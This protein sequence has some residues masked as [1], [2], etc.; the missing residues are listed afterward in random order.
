MGVATLRVI[1][2]ETGEITEHSGCPHCQQAQAETEELTKK[3]KGALLEIRKLK[4]DRLAEI[5]GAPERP[6]VELLHAVWKVACK[7]R[8]DL[9][10]K[11]YERM[12]AMVKKHGLGKCLAAIAGASYDCAKTPRKN[13]T[14]KKHDDLE[15]IFRESAKVLDFA[16]RVPQGWTPNVEKVAHIGGVSEQ[17]VADILEGRWKA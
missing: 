11:D 15:L 8:R 9:D 13:G 12:N 3:F 2:T 17:W 7:K 4:A 1:D 5:L 10:F 6:Q 14:W 16:E